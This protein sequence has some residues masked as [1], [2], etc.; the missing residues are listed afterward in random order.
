MLNALKHLLSDL[1]SMTYADALA[2]S[3]KTDP[4][5]VAL[6]ASLG[7]HVPSADELW[8]YRNNSIT[9]LRKKIAKLEAA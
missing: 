7:V 4:K 1:E 8:E 6:V 3:N 5:A 2:Q 9:N